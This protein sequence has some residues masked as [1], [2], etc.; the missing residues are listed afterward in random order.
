MA[1][2]RNAG[3]GIREDAVIEAAWLY[4]HDSLNQND[5]ATRLGVSRA[6]VV[7]YLQEARA[8]G[9]VRIS[10][11]EE[12]FT[13][14]RLAHDLCDRFGLK[15]AYVAPAAAGVEGTLKR[16]AR[17]AAEWLPTLLEPGDR[18]GIAWGQT[19]FETVEA[20]GQ[21]QTEDVKVLQLVGSVPSPFGF[22]A[23]ACS[24]NLARKLS[25]ECINLFA[26]VILSNAE[27]ARILMAEPIIAAQLATLGTCTKAIFA[28]GSCLPDSHVVGAGVASLAELDVY[29]AA[30]AKGVLC[31]RFIDAQGSPLPGPMD[32]RMMGMTLDRL[33]GLQMGLL[34]SCGSEKVVPMHSVLTGGYATHLVTDA[35]TATELL[36]IAR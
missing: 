31:G 23:E 7:T 14:H 10:L 20:M 35:D 17:A 3:R 1:T 22:T 21:I 30:G 34:V 26:P 24:T 36:D 18:L 13:R 16:V 11:A 15:A 8:S 25:A 6:T 5:I 12:P 19:V 28:A 2:P 29:K 4:F 32:G 33:R 9:L 27:N